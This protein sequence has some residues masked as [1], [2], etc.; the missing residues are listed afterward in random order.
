MFER[1]QRRDVKVLVVDLGDNQ[2]GA[3]R[4]SISPRQSP[5]L[6]ALSSWIRPF[7]AGMNLRGL[8][9]ISG[10]QGQS[11]LAEVTSQK[12]DSARGD[13]RLERRQPPLFGPSLQREADAVLRWP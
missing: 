1:L 4:N 13:R 10:R 9:V 7:P 5:F 11:P 12:A 8:I 3:V 6:F 2:H